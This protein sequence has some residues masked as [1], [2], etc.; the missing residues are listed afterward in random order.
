M[1]STACDSPW[2]LLE[3]V[4]RPQCGNGAAGADTWDE[5]EGLSFD[6]AL[7]KYVGEFGKGQV[8]S[9][10]WQRK[11]SCTPTVLEVREGVGCGVC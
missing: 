3:A 7:T 10:T 6:D 5:Q 4:V 8:S 11:S 9:C 1:R 2:P